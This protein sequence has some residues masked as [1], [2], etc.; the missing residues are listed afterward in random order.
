VNVSWEQFDGLVKRARYAFYDNDQMLFNS[1]SYLLKLWLDDANRS[2]KSSAVHPS[3]SAEVQAK[4]IREDWREDR[5][6]DPT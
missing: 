5:P 3:G 4:A 2:L 6:G 1:L